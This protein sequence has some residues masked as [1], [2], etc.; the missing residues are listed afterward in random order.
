MKIINHFNKKK[1]ENKNSSTNYKLLFL[2]FTL[3][4]FLEGFSQNVAYKKWNPALDTLQVLE[5]QAWPKQVK[6]FYDRLPAKAENSVRNEVWDL[7]RNSTGLSLRFRTNATEIIVKYAVTD[8]LQFPHMP[9]TGVSGVDLY[10]KNS[11]GKWLW[12][13]GR[14]SFGDTITY[15]FRGMLSKDA[16][17][18]PF[19]YTLY[20]PLYNSVK[21]LELNVPD[22]SLFT[23]LPA[24]KENP[25][26]VYG[27]SIAQGACATRAGLAWT[28]ILSRKLDRPVINLGF[29]GNGR[30][31]KEVISLI[32]E[33]DA[34]LY[35]LDC[36]PNLT[37]VN[38]TNAE[39]K[40]RIV[41]SV[42][43]LQ[44]KRPGIPI[45]LTDH[46][47]YS[48]E[49]INP[50]SKEEYQ[51]L[52]TAL[53]QEYDSLTA[54][55]TKNIYLLTKS[56][57]NQD[58]ETMVD[59]THP[60]DM[61]MMRYADAYEKKIR[62]IIN[63]SVGNIST[64][65][66]V[67]QHRDS[68]YDWEVRHNEVLTHNK[69]HPPQLVLMGNSITHYWAGEP[70]APIARGADSW[71][72]FF[73]PR[74]AVN[75][76]FGWDRIENVLWRVYH[77]ELDNIAPKQIVLMIGTNN[78]QFNSDE[79]IITGL[80]FLIKAIRAKQP[81]SNILVMGILPRRNMQVRVSTL[82]EKLS[83]IKW[84]SKTQ[85]ADA[86]RLFLK[87]DQKIDESL[88]SDGLHPNEKGYSRLGEFI[89]QHIAHN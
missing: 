32:T 16:Y 82:N 64:T 34:K 8:K 80:Q 65:I 2:L 51:L 27:T 58:I 19:E 4:F 66:P 60:N 11:D 30:L 61:G 45:L 55:D 74:N 33:V 56:E 88:F 10:A 87:S 31:E 71:N 43:Q 14:F 6:N 79:E 5:G 3:G 1:S 89:T 85:Y 48:D 9:A 68:N 57:I 7:S 17:D 83:K 86:G 76:G 22:S 44:N 72:K 29:S 67:T 63:E 50:D 15:R 39:L 24:R 73:A 13:A 81:S 41:E 18:N 26:L 75:L 59:G 69:I 54:A 36:L 38:V 84:D 23:P 53:K 42:Q 77:G 62:A 35:V 46:D 21:W 37:P 78:L 25:I 12:C 49:E 28:N 70:V 52:N 47:G 40:K 20:L